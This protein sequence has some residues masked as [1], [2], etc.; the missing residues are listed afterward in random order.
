M[1]S[2]ETTPW[3]RTT[4]EHLET[5][6]WSRGSCEGARRPEG[7]RAAPAGCPRGG[8]ARAQSGPVPEV[9]R[10]GSG[11]GSDEP[12]RVGECG[13]GGRYLGR[14]RWGRREEGGGRKRGSGA[15]QAT[16][17][18]RPVCSG[19]VAAGVSAGTWE[20]GPGARQCAFRGPYEPP[21]APPVPAFMHPI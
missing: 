12:F 15:D 19:T 10:R 2:P 11:P 1:R 14:P 7:N 9:V 4:E 21:P 18:P 8:A 20:A 17:R 13:C 3:S 16:L 5:G 6:R